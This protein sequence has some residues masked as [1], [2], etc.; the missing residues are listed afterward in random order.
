MKQK[1]D[2]THLDSIKDIQSKFADN[3]NSIGN[4]TIERE[5]LKEQLVN[6]EHES[7]NYFNVFK[8]LKQEEEKLFADLK[9]RY[10]EGQINIQE[11]TFDPL[12]F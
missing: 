2:K 11:G 10:G 12:W 7:E 5:Y 4:I 6:L 8:Q 9:Q 1:L 3:S